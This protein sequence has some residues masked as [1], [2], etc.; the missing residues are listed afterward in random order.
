MTSRRESFELLKAKRAKLREL[1]REYRQKER[2]WENYA[3]SIRLERVK[4]GLQGTPNPNFVSNKE[5]H[6][7]DMRAYYA[8]ESQ[9]QAEIDALERELGI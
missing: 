7:E 5:S 1:Q 3:E 9:L 6:D 4:H 2:S 8:K